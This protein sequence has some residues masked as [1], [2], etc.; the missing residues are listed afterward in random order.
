MIR[1]IK[2]RQELA[3]MVY[4]RY[5]NILTNEDKKSLENEIGAAFEAYQTA[6]DEIADLITNGQTTENI[7]RYI[8]N[9]KTKAK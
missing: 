3:Q 2:K 9:I 7:A 1:N 8:N 4:N 5:G 6:L